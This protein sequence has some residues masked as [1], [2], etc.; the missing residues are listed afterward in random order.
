MQ[1]T[2]FALATAPGRAAVAVMRISGPES[3]GVLRRLA[4]AMP[5][6][7]RAALRRLR[8]GREILDQALV[9]WLPGPG[10]FTGEDSAELHL[11]GGQA[12]VEA[13]SRALGEL[14]LRLA[15]PG[16]FSRRAF[17][18]GKLDLTQAEA[19]ADLVDAETD[20]QRRQALG[21]LG[22]ELSARYL[23]W[24][25]R[26][27]EALARLEAAV[28]FPDE[29]LPETLDREIGGKIAALAD[30][31]EA[32]LADEHRG[33]RVREGYRIALIG[34]PNAGKSSLLNRLAG[35][36]A[37][38]VTDR[39]GT[40]RDVIEVPVIIGGFKALYA[41]MAGIR[42]TDDPIEVEGVRRARAWAKTADL[43]VWVVDGSGGPGPGGEAAALMAKGDLV[44]LNKADRPEGPAV[45][46]AMK[47]AERE[48][49]GV[50]RACAVADGGVRDL[51]D[52]ISAKVQGLCAPADFPAVTRLRHRRRLE[53]AAQALRRGGLALGCSPE[54]A[55]EDLRHAATALG[56]I[57]G[58][59]DPEE[60]LGEVFSS[61]CIGK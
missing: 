16:E 61:F 7:R 2:I 44:V 27:I 52:A 13:V 35:R 17:Q 60:V 31:L 12:T 42:E 22:G 10:S 58:R 11:H 37:A 55:A 38:I 29:D 49:A 21:Q 51:A 43:R 18:H 14:G 26:L 32:A 48:C 33:E 25:R 46:A 1:D 8:R 53:E 15:E 56:R 9:L 20:S 57:A 34:A 40:T 47:A 24:R 41:D 39:P 19:I 3:A 30:D 23:A 4:G 5:A 36:E 28:D 59:I 50:V 54:L 45:A 6:P